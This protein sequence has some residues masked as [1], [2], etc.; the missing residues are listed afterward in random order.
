MQLH[1]IISVPKDVFQGPL[2]ENYSKGG[3]LTVQS[4][5]SKECQL[6]N[7][8]RTQKK[9]SGLL[10]CDIC[11]EISKLL[12]NVSYGELSLWLDIFTVSL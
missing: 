2:M 9:H 1:N 11:G 10:Y 12:I 3:V 4:G 8:L 5:L 6:F 7:S